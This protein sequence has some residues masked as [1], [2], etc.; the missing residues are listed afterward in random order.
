TLDLNADDPVLRLFGVE[1]LPGV[2]V[3]GTVSKVGTRKE[4]STLRLA[5]PGT[6]DGTLR[7]GRKW[8]SGRLGGK[9]IRARVPGSRASAADVRSTATRAQML[10]VARRLAQRPRLY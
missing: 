6:P 5:G 9:R 7:I 3:S 1:Y 10:R 8:I 2:R 4:S